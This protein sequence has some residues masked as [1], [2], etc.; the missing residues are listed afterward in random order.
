MSTSRARVVPLLA[1]VATL[2]PAHSDSHAGPDLTGS[3]QCHDVRGPR[4]DGASLRVADAFGVAE[5]A[6]VRRMVKICSPVTSTSSAA[7]TASPLVGYQIRQQV[8]S[9]RPSRGHDLVTPLGRFEDVTLGPPRFLLAPAAFGSDFPAPSVGGY[10]SCR[11][12]QSARFRAR[13]LEVTDEFGHYDVNLRD[14]WSFCSAAAVDG[15]PAGDTSLLCFF[16]QT[17]PR[18]AFIDAPVRTT[19]PLG[20]HERRLRRTA[21]LC[22]P[23]EVDAGGPVEEIVLTLV[24]DETRAASAEIGRVGGV[25]QA[26]GAAGEVYTLEIPADALS[27]TTAITLTPV[28]AVGGLPA[29]GGLLAAVQFAPEGLVLFRPARLTI[30]VPADFDPDAVIPFAYAGDGREVHLVAVSVAGRVLAFDI[31]HFSGAGAGSGSSANAGTIAAAPTAGLDATFQNQLAQLQAQVKQQICGG[32]CQTPDLAEQFQETVRVVAVDLLLNWFEALQTGPL[33]AAP[34][35]DELLER[36]YREFA[37][38]DATLL[39]LLCVLDPSDPTGLDCS[40]RELV[41][42]DR[43]EEGRRALARGWLA[44]F[45]RARD[46]CDDRRGLDLLAQA[47]LASLREALAEVLAVDSGD[48]EQTIAATYGCQVEVGVERLSEGILVDEEEE[49][50]VLVTLELAGSREPLADFELRLDTTLGCGTFP[51]F[52][53]TRTVTTDAA[54]RATVVVEATSSCSDVVDLVV[55]DVLVDES[56][57]STVPVVFGNDLA[58]PVAFGKTVRFEVPVLECSLS[59]V[60]EG[61]VLVATREDLEDL[62]GVTEITGDLRILE[63]DLTDVGPLACL[64][65]VGGLLEITDNPVLAD[66]GGLRR[67]ARVDSLFLNDVPALPEIRLPALV[68]A[69][70]V[71]SVGFFESGSPAVLDMPLLAAPAN[72]GVLGTIRVFGRRRPFSVDLRAPQLVGGWSVRVSDGGCGAPGS[73]RVDVGEISSGGV[74]DVCDTQI[75]WR[76]GDVANRLQFFGQGSMRGSIGTGTLGEVV[77]NGVWDELNAAFGDIVGDFLMRG[78][79]VSSGEISTGL[80]GGDATVDSSTLSIDVLAL[81]DVEGDLTITDNH[82]FT[83]L[84]ARDYA[85]TVAVGGR[86]TIF[87]NLP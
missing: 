71:S 10:L 22:L 15:T 66:L 79:T 36:G 38:W 35:S 60:R 75:D 28:P 77:L 31:L 24:T 81:G 13:G 44:A 63:T 26:V 76:S 20:I 86:T 85:D 78:A 64:E 61:D 3:V 33:D 9:R 49:F 62:D 50:D 40:A 7:A 55:I 6:Q 43:I 23:A 82:G 83:N 69:Q 29:D 56:G 12:V 25:V 39:G 19:D 68:S 17:E 47:L 5:V 34:N 80:V 45:E 73:I 57:G 4:L 42:T 84:E 41:F 2:G 65:E 18:R 30:A 21:E 54:G 59:E 48:L 46:D 37:A 67:L 53:G 52:G 27:E 32:S 1:L 72:D 14:P 58:T 8:P 11:R 70:R 51:G 87:A 74:T 16:A